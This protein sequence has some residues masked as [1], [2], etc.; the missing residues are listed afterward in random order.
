MNKRV[1]NDGHGYV[2]LKIPTKVVIRGITHVEYG[3]VV[4]EQRFIFFM[5]DH[6]KNVKIQIC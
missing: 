6:A 3:V 5:F 4:L 2:S 1:L